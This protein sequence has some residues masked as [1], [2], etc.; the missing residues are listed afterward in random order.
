MSLAW[1]SVGALVV[2]VILSCTT[3]I[4]VGVLS[5]A[6]ALIVGVF[7]GGMSPDAV[8]AG[9]PVSLFITLVGVT[10]LFSIAECNGTLARLTARAVRLCRGHAG[11][12]PI[13]FFAL[14]L[15]LSTIGA[16]ATPASA[17]LAPPAMAIAGQA[18]VPP[19]LMAIMAGHG[20]LAGTLSPFA[21]NGIIAD[22]VMS[23]WVSRASNGRPSRTRRSPTR[24]SASAV[25]FCSVAGDCSDDATP[26]LFRPGSPRSRR[27]RRATGR[28]RP[29]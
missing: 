16:G 4:N 13:M 26:M 5:L 11:V 10:L 21:P 2:A 25:S 18:G 23:P 20:V 24:S 29:G 17:L 9:F 12:L 1:I 15:I 7:L 8:L 14:G 27:W 6:F 22:G 3:T 19:L 28:R